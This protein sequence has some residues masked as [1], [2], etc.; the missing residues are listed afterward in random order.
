MVRSLPLPL[1]L[2][3]L[4]YED[5]NITAPETVS[6]TVFSPPVLLAA[7]LR[8]S[9]FFVIGAIEG[10]A[11][12]VGAMDEAAI[13]SGERH[14]IEVTLDD[15]YF[16][17]RMFSADTDGAEQLIAAL[18]CAETELAGFKHVLQPLMGRGQLQVLMPLPSPRHPLPSPLGGV[19][20]PHGAVPPPPPTRP[21]THPCP[22]HPPDA[23]ALYR[24]SSATTSRR[25]GSRCPT[26]PP[27]RS[28][29]PR[30]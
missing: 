29:R 14:V 7:S 2:L 3:P 4:Q 10:T 26:R 23:R 20:A 21:H 12:L 25:C 11:T 27:T 18:A 24:S 6:L 1:S 22:H 15:A 9:A 17:E 13:R 8:V 28:A 5:Y 16:D 19:P 30:R